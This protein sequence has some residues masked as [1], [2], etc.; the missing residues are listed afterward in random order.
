LY[1]SAKNFIVFFVLLALNKKDRKPGFIFWHFVLLYGIGRFLVD[2][3]RVGEA[4]F[5]GI[6]TGQWLC[7]AMIAAALIFIIKEKYY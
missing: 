3:Y 1:E 5:L 6:Q 4:Y 7:I 2:F